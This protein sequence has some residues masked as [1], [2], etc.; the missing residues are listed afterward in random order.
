M[1]KCKHI[2][3][4]GGILLLAC[5]AFA[6]N[7]ANGLV[8]EISGVY[9]VEDFRFTPCYPVNGF[10]THPDP[11]VSTIRMENPRNPA[12]Y[13][14]YPKNTDVHITI[15]ENFMKQNVYSWSNFIAM[16]ASGNEHGRIHVTFDP[17]ADP[18]DNK[19]SEHFNS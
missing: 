16:D 7:Y 8:L 10:F 4:T 9:V 18:A 5:A 11:R 2:I 6:K 19:C 13:I 15:H 17:P 14:D 3:I 12:Q 1:Q